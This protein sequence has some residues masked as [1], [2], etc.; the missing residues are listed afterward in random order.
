MI[1]KKS[2]FRY[3]VILIVLI[4]DCFSC[5]NAYKDKLYDAKQDKVISDSLTMSSLYVQA[6][7]L[8]YTQPD[9]F[10]LICDSLLDLATFHSDTFNIAQANKLIGNFQLIKAN[11]KDC[12]PYYEKALEGFKLLNDSSNIGRTYM[13]IGI[14]F[15]Y[16]G[17]YPLVFFQYLKA[18]QFLKGTK[19]HDGLALLY[20]NLSQ[21]YEF[22]EKYDSAMFYLT[23]ANRIYDISNSE[24][25]R[26][27][28]LSK[29]GLLY[30]KMGNYQLSVDYHLKAINFYESKRNDYLVIATYI[31][32]AHQYI[33][34][35]QPDNAINALKKAD[36]LNFKIGNT[37]M[38]AHIYNNLGS[39]F[40][41]MHNYNDAKLYFIKALSTCDIVNENT[42]KATI[43]LNLG[44]LYQASGNQLKSEEYILEGVKLTGGLGHLE[45]L[46]NSYKLYANYYANSGSYQEAFQY[47]QK[48]IVLKDSIF[49]KEKFKI[50]EELNTKYETS[51]KEEELLFA[52]ELLKKNKWTIITLSITGFLLITLLFLGFK[53]SQKKRKAN[54]ELVKRN[55]ELSELKKQS[56]RK[57]N[58]VR[59]TTEKID[60]IM[61]EMKNLMEVKKIYRE[62]DLTLNILAD[63][64]GTNREYLS[65]ILNNVICKNFNDYVN[66]FR[67]EEAKNILWKEAR[68]TNQQLTMLAIANAVGFKNTSTFNPLFKQATGLTPSEYKKASENI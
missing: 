17:N 40:F 26:S 9:S 56:H 51:Q 22:I 63:R 43:L 1:T 29:F 23:K 20:G 30:S 16:Q 34:L 65:Q 21:Y 33:N 14:S 49:N 38:Q 36:S 32:L 39:A 67:I 44:E 41:L 2:F 68:K 45:L 47:T 4:T 35:G 57:G 27:D 19:D 11:Y 50:V 12:I 10:K 42:L 28:L 37:L 62:E 3:V 25:N 66:D 58:G 53:Y 8:M 5:N 54:I 52:N 46:A 7:S 24:N 48:Y 61:I 13:N 6:K 64:I 60:S 15:L 31:N 55:K 18:E 59:L